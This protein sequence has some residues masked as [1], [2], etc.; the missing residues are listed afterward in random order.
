MPSQRILGQDLTLLV[1]RGTELVIDPL[2]DITNFNGE[3]TFKTLQQGFLG[4]FADRT[5]FVYEA[6]KFDFELQIHTALYFDFAMSIKNKA[7]RRT[8]D[9]VFNL[10]GLITFPGTGEVTNLIFAD[11]AFGPIPL[12]VGGR[13]EYVKTKLQGICSNIDPQKM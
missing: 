7:Q 9:V 10:S 11:V 5:D 12:N 6:A 4:E 1:S 8:P 2:T 3:M 13:T